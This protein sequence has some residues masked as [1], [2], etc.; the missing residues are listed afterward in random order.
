MPRTA[1][2]FTQALNPPDFERRTVNTLNAWSTRFHA[3]LVLSF[4]DPIR[5]QQKHAEA[6]KG[7]NDE[8]H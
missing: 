7:A 6:C 8:H 2:R 1:D 5:I 3:S 4:L